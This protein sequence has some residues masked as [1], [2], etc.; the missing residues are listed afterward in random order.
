MAAMS[1]PAP[2]DELEVQLAQFETTIERSAPPP[3]NPCV[4]RCLRC[5]ESR[6]RRAA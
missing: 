6:N 1:D 5:V 3:V 2:A 4:C